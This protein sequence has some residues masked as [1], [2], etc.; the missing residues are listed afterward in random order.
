MSVQFC[1]IAI[2]SIPLESPFHSL[3]AASLP[4]KRDII[5]SIV[6]SWQWRSN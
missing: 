6:M 3:L 1:P 4:I 5:M 2:R